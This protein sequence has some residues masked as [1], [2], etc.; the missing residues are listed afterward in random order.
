M[1][2]PHSLGAVRILVRQS[3]ATN[4]T[5]G[6]PYLTAHSTQLTTTEVLRKPIQEVPL[7]HLAL[8]TREELLLGHIG[9]LL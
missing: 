3:L 2:Q 6:Q 4:Q 1:T 9:G 5:G 7:E 8:V